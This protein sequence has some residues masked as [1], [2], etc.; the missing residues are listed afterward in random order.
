MTVN[1]ES[2]IP[3]LLVMIRPQHF[4]FNT[5]TAGT[6]S[7]QQQSE[8]SDLSVQALVEFDA[9]VVQLRGAGI[10]IQVF[11]DQSIPLPDALF[12]NNWLAVLPDKTLTIFPMMAQIR[13]KEVRSDIVNWI[14]AKCEI[15]QRIDLR[16]MAKENQFLEGTGSIVF[17]HEAKIAFACES[18]RTSIAL[19][20]TFCDR[21]G[22][23]PFS[24]ESLDLQGNHIYH[25]NVILS[26]TSHVVL[27][28]LESVENQM[29]RS[30]LKLKLQ[31]GGKVLIEIN[32]QQTKAFLG[33][34]FEVYDKMGASYMLM[35]TAAK[36]VLRPDQLAVIECYSKIITVNIPIIEQIG[37][38]GI[39]CMVAGLFA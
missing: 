29:E 8:R 25:T 26:I 7:F 18:Q 13:Q 20:E 1:F 11:E 36:Q 2:K 24:F 35:S 5:E 3:N 14:E 30:F 9:V 28:N 33:N 15:K 34:V 23:S 21:I 37:G 27:V 31:L 38:G 17:D 22:Y 39:R 6:N 4:G 10:A 12:P 16:E 19:F 32:H